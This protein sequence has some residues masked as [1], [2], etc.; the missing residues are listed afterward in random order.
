MVGNKNV[1]MA[2]LLFYWLHKA[3]QMQAVTIEMFKQVDPTVCQGTAGPF[4]HQ[5]E[6][7]PMP[8]KLGAF[9]GY[10]IQNLVPT[11]CLRERKGQ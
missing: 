11:N 2:F 1:F 10:P 7:V 4:Y 3:F 9:L 5:A 8:P 6:M